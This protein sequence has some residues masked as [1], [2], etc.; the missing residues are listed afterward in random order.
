MAVV[1]VPAPL[2]FTH[3]A[4]V[5]RS[6]RTSDGHGGWIDEWAPVIPS[7]LCRVTDARLERRLDDA[8]R[9]VADV[10]RTLYCRP[11]ADLRQG[12]RIEIVG[13]TYDVEAVEDQP[14]GIYR[15]AHLIA[16]STR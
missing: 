4:K 12:D 10:T 16:E 14:D 15:K 5:L 3:R 9:L 1:A 7:L 2:R 6:T 13:E 11:D 8:G